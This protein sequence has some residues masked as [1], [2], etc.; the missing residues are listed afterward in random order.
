MTKFKNFRF[1]LKKLA[2]LVRQKRGR[3]GLRSVSLQAGVS[4]STL[5]RI[6]SEK[7]LPD[8]ETFLLLCHWLDVS[9]RRFF[10]VGDGFDSRDDQKESLTTCDDVVDR[11]KADPTLNPEVA[12]AL[13][14]LIETA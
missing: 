1:S 11:L 4:I 6:E 10:D 14:V 13:A 9:P 2:R 12:N 5:S 7:G 8:M 3:L